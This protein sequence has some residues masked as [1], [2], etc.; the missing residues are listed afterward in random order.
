MLYPVQPGPAYPLPLLDHGMG[1]LARP[2]PVPAIAAGPRIPP[3]LPYGV[4]PI[5]RMGP[6]LVNDIP[7]S[8]GPQLAGY[9]ILQLIGPVEGMAPPDLAFDIAVQRLAAVEMLATKAISFGG[10]GVVNL[11][12]IYD[13]IGHVIATGSA[14]QAIPIL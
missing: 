8:V 3:S 5:G 9:T 6:S 1:A 12:I 7:I 10:N 13:P 2:L 4:G 14:V 11:R